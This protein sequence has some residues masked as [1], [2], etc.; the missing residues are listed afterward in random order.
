MDPVAVAEEQLTAA[1]R[2]NIEQRYR[3]V[4]NKQLTPASPAPRGEGPPK[5]KGKGVDSINWGNLGLSEEEQDLE[6]QQAALD[7]LKRDLLIWKAERVSK[8]ARCVK[9][10]VRGH[11]SEVPPPKP[12]LLGVIRLQSLGKWTTVRS[13]KFPK[14]VTLGK[15]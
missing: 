12:L 7:L 11:A 13:V 3:H 4:A 1:Q 14:I 9:K 6:A 5:S 15:H 2:N 8:D 10:T